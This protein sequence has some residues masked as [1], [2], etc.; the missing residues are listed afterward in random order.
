MVESFTEKMTLDRGS[1]QVHPANVR[2]EAC[3][4]EAGRSRCFQF[5]VLAE[6]ERLALMREEVRDSTCWFSFTQSGKVRTAVSEA[7]SS[8]LV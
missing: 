4:K 5:E 6:V 2:T 8:R 1:T 7:C 3:A